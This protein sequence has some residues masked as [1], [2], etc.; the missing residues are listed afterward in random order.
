M[1]VFINGA[2][3]MACVAI[4]VF[5]LKFWKNTRDRLFAMFAVSFWLLACDRI[6]I[7]GIGQSETSTPA[8]YLLRLA[9]FLLIIEAIVEKNRRKYQ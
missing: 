4:G 3:A 8:E 9:A 7:V 2:I 6:V 1:N 5:F